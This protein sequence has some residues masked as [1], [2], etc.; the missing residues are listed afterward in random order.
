MM[1]TKAQNAWWMG[2]FKLLDAPHWKQGGYRLQKY[3]NM[4]ELR[5]DFRYFLYL[6]DM[7]S[8]IQI[9]YGYPMG[10]NPTIPWQPH[11]ILDMA[12]LILERSDLATVLWRLNMFAA[13]WTFARSWCPAFLILIP[14]EDKVDVISPINILFCYVTIMS[15]GER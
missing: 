6:F 13:T 8:G 11:W 12:T 7:A 2:R 15:L 1:F 5:L 4:E 3:A 9:R 10:Q 14:H